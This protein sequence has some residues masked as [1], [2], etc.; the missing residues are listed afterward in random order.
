MVHH[1]IES[2]CGLLSIDVPL[3][4]E[5]VWIALDSPDGPRMQHYEELISGPVF[6]FCEEMLA[7]HRCE[8]ELAS[9]ISERLISVLDAFILTGNTKAV[10]L[11]MEFE[12]LR[13]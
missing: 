9:V 1:V 8:I 11:V 4:V 7:D 5:L 12:R 2:A 3:C 13:A 6:G 10:G